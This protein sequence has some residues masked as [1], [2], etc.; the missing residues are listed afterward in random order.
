M[1]DDLV[2]VDTTFDKNITNSYFMS[3]Q[4]ALDG[5]SF[6]VL[7]PVRNEY[8]AFGHF[9]F[10]VPDHNW[11]RTQELIVSNQWFQHRFK[12]VLVLFSQAQAYLIPEPLYVEEKAN[13]FFEFSDANK[14]E[15]MEIVANKIKMPDPLNVFRMP[16]FS[17]E[18]QVVHVDFNNEGM[19]VVVCQG[20]KLKFCNS[21]KVNNE[22]DFI[23]FLLYVFSQLELP[24]KTT[25]VRF[26]GVDDKRKAYYQLARKYIR[27]A[28]MEDKPYNFSYAP[29]MKSVAGNKYSNF[30]NLP[31]CVS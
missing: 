22:H 27:H 30:L 12:K 3:I 31:L 2:V 10:E 5:L 16:D 8:I 18:N 21:F 19:D 29:G 17:T 4:I 28:L 6:A 23:F 26:S 13:N 14:V 20:Y 15:H 7:D 24:V 25:E 9:P 11:V 1:F